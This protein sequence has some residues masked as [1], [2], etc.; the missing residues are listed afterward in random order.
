MILKWISPDGTEIEFSRDATDY[1]LQR[2]YSGLSDV[3]AIHQPTQAPYQ[4]GQ[5]LID[6]VLDVREINFEI[7]IMA[8]DLETLQSQI[9]ALSSAFNPKKGS[10]ILSYTNEAGA[11]Y[12]CYCIGNR[13]PKLSTSD[14][15]LTWQRA[16]I[17]LIAH[18]PYW[19]SG[20]PNIKYLS[21]ITTDFFP[22]DISGNFLGWNS[23]T[24]IV[25]NS[26]DVAAPVTI[27][28]A[29]ECVDPILTNVTTGEAIS[30]D[31]S[32]SAGDLFVITTGY[33]N[34]TAVYYPSGGTS[35]NGF[36]Y[37]LSTSVLWSLALGDN[38]ITLTNTSIAEGTYVSIEWREKYVGVA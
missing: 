19:Y 26:G 8:E 11:E 22:F 35:E 36:P 34:K 27:S 23:S 6:S 5:T 1:K 29:G 15:G 3:P 9:R 10:G 32:M 14:R 37:L 21:S 17:D 12:W 4:D 20:T 31:L 33:G 25:T 30:I 16:Y 2:N 28:I 7:M 38:T 24:E 13:T 18:D